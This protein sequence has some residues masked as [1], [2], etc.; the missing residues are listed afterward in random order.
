LS[1]GS[2]TLP[3]FSDDKAD[4]TAVFLGVTSATANISRI[5]FSVVTD[6]TLDL[7]V[8]T[9]SLSTEQPVVLITP[10]PSVLVLAALAGALV[11]WRRRLTT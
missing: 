11:V 10:E 8:N 3:G 9:L 6:R 2:H 7:A 1:L 4:D 5:Q